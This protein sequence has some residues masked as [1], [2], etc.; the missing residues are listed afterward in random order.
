MAGVGAVLEA[1][2]LLVGYGDTPV[3][4]E[5]TVAV[6]PGEVLAVVGVNGAGKSTVVRTLA[7]R[8]LPL[9]GDALVHGLPVMPDAVLFRRQVAAVF[10]EDV[11]FPSLTVREHLLLVA[12]GHSVASP[13]KAVA[14]E[15]KFF[16]L[17]GRAD[18]VPDSLSSGQRRR[19]LL[20]AGFI[21]PSSLLILDE[22]EQRL[23]P[24]MRDALGRRIRGH[25]GAGAA[26]VLVTHDPRLL[27]QTATQCLVV[28]DF[29]ELVDPMQGASA[30]A[31]S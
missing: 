22:P 9:A 12:R 17:L 14:A 27:V 6:E 15:L 21:R 23:D 19:L 30:I 16:G 10:D 4:G 28:G 26:V 11:F 3:C 8:Q 7:G 31:G 1:R 13:D 24:V 25:A 29:V 5:V 2:E 18:A 20:A